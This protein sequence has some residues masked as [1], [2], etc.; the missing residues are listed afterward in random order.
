MQDLG[1]TWPRVFRI[2]A[3]GMS[4]HQ[5]AVALLGTFEPV[6]LSHPSHAGVSHGSSEQPG[7]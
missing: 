1:R 2:N 3:L 5:R 7:P 6:Y 4:S